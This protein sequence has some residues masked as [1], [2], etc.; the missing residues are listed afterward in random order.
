MTE[1]RSGIYNLLKNIVSYS[2]ITLAVIY[3]LGHIIIAMTCNY[4]ITGA[5]LDLAAVDAI[6]EPCINGVWFYILHKA[7]DNF[8]KKSP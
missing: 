3:T 7:Y 2:S 1:F 5:S 8:R 4:L 6:V